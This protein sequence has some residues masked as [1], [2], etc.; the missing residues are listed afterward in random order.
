MDGRGV[1][2][3]HSRSPQDD[4]AANDTEDTPH[5]TPES[6]SKQGVVEYT[7][8]VHRKVPKTG[9]YCVGVVPVTLIGNRG[10]AGIDARATTHANFTG[11]VTF[12]NQFDGELPAVEYPKIGVGCAIA[13]LTAVLWWPQCGVPPPRHWLGHSVRAVLPRAAAD[14]V[15]HLWDDRI[16]RRRDACAVR[17]LP[18]YQQAWRWGS[19][20]R[21]PARREHPQRREEQPELLPLADCLDGSECGDAVPWPG[22]A[23]SVGSH[24]SSLY[25]WRW[26]QRAECGSR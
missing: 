24:C 13:P 2:H 10:L 20:R 4:K 18:L 6:E 9:Y 15:L 16:P 23:A 19:E 11:L 12:R 25:L 5:T 1:G 22:D 17:V 26:V 8:P 14:A 21:V 7:S 3:T